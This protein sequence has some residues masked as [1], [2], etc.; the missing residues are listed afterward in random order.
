MQ[1]LTE[2][3]GV[4]APVY[5]VFTKADLIAGFNDFFHDTDRAERDRV[6]GATLPLQPPQHAARTCWPSSTQHFDELHDGLKEMSLASMARQPQQ[7]DAR[8]ACSPS[9]SNSRRSRA[10]LRAFIATLF[11]ENP[12]QF[13]PVFRGFYFTSALQ[14]GIGVR[15][16]VASA[17]RSAST[18]SCSEQEARARRTSQHGYFLLDLFRKVIFADKELVAQLHQPGQ[19]RACKYGAFFAA[20]ALLGWRWAAGAGRTWATASWWPTCR[21][22]STRWCKLQEKRIDLQSRFEAL[23]ILQDRIEQLEKYRDEPA[24]DAGL[25]PVPGRALERKLRDEYFAG[26]REVMLRA[27]RRRRSKAAWPR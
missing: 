15:T 25:R 12:Y 3:L 27:G 17:S 26:V 13:K 2:K 14:E 11:E 22:T 23:E 16:F 9:R 19:R 7:R 8:R 4:Y 6:W 24:A 10:P 18:S 21:P 5:V 1:E 20:T